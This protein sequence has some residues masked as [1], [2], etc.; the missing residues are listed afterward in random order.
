MFVIVPLRISDNNDQGGC[1]VL[2]CH[3]WYFCLLELVK[4]VMMFI[5]RHIHRASL[6]CVIVSKIQSE[7][8]F[9]INLQCNIYILVM[10]I[11]E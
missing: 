11:W 6:R 2:A 3:V 10:E 9:F 4:K 8:I 1:D 7:V 5:S